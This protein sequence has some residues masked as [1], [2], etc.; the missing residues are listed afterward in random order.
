MLIFPL[1]LLKIL[2]IGGLVLCGA[3][4][5]ALVVFWWMDLKNKQIW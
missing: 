5:A 3:G 4:A 1:W 2:V